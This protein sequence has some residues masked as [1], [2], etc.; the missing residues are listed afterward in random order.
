MFTKDSL[1]KEKISIIAKKLLAYMKNFNITPY[2]LFKKFDEDN[3]GLISNIDF[4]Q[5]LKKYLNIDAALADPFFAYLDFYHIG[6]VD[7]ET[8]MTQLTYVNENNITEKLDNIL[9]LLTNNNKKFTEEI[10]LIKS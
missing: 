8:F 2:G 1:S 4:N 3:N 10:N 5:G 6:M 9:N 7:F